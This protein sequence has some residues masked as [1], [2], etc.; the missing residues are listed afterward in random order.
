MSVVAENL[1][2]IRQEISAACVKASRLP[3][4]ITL[5]AVGKNHPV[6]KLIEAYN[7]GHRVFAENYVQ[8]YIKKAD[9]LK[10]AG[11]YGDIEWHY[12]GS[13]QTNKVKYIVGRTALIHTVDRE[14]LAAEI[15]KRAESLNIIQRV[16]VEVNTGGEGS[17]TGVQPDGLFELL[18]TLNEMK[19]IRCEGLMT[20]P[21]FLPPDEVKPYFVKL[22]ELYSE[23]K[24][25]GLLPYAKHL[26]MGMSGDFAAAIECGAT[27]IRVGT[28]IFGQRS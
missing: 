1:K 12:I 8:E 5:V 24:L 20:L 16:L 17:K 13:L 25:K 6:E 18:G 14:K 4:E 10:E 22:N 28:A 21:P 27:I 15:D 11:K 23:T 26:S 7:T 3:D 2:R 9:V 19:H